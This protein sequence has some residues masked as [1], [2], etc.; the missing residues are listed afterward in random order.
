MADVEAGSDG[1]ANR[2]PL[3]LPIG[4]QKGDEEEDKE[5][6]K[7]GVDGVDETLKR[8][9]LFLTVLGFKH[10]SGWSSTLWWG[11]FFLVGVVVP[12]V[13]LQLTD[14]SG[15]CEKYQISKFE[16]DIVASQA[17]L[18]AVSL[19]CLSHNLRKF[20]IGRFLFVDRCT[21]HMAPFRE[22]YVKMISVSILFY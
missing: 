15:D 7:V 18:A 5:D 6:E 19:I 4:S 1:S 21:G 2:A 3:L 10:S 14:C 20:G 9:E 16:L 12:V 13:I 11:V 8:L 22:E 17:C